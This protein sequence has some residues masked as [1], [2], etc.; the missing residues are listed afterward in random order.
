MFRA[1]LAGYSNNALSTNC[2][3]SQTM[4][5]DL[6]A[7][8][9][10]PA[11]GVPEPIELARYTATL[12]LKDGRGYGDSREWYQDSDPSVLNMTGRVHQMAPNSAWLEDVWPFARRATERILSKIDARGL[13]VAPMSTGNYGQRGKVTNAWDC[14]NFGHYDAYSNAETYRALRNVIAL[15]RAAGDNAFTARV[16]RAADKMQKAYA[17]CFY[18]K[19]TGWLGSWRSKDGVLHDYGHYMV[20]MPACLYGLVTPAQA[21]RIVARLDA[22][23]RELGIVNFRYVLPTSLL[24]TRADDFQGGYMDNPIWGKG[25]REDGADGFGIYC[26][27][28][29]SINGAYYTLL[30][31]S[32]F[33]SR[34]VVDQMIEHILD[35]Y[36]LGRLTGG[37]RTGTEFHT[38]EGITCGYE[39]TIVG[40][41]P[42]LLAIAIHQGL[43][44][45]LEPECWPAEQ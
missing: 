15:A 2:H 25:V 10:A 28:C 12:A 31:M 16:G 18:N 9:R 24:P 34:K 4:V 44:K 23:R 7:H 42:T 19:K 27:G 32:R 11:P 33:G 13:V 29:L 35:G 41:P 43:V 14:V 37:V 39:G 8:S 21:R 17:P 1:E 30:A 26:N 45:P 40:E 20:N 6:A 5:A 38:L 22:K 36:A 3:L